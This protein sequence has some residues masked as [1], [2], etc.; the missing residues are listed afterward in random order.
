MGEHSDEIQA[1]RYAI[2][3]RRSSDESS[4]KQ[5]KSIPDQLQFCSELAQREGITVPEKYIFSESASA[6]TANNR[7]IFNKLLA[8]IRAGH[9]DGIISWHPDRLSRNMLEAGTIID[10]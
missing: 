7:P 10:L 4:G 6:K 1:S 8:L 3:A 9:I 2:Y 5:Y